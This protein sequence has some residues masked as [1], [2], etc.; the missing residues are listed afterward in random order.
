M[1]ATCK[2]IAESAWFQQ[3]ITAVILFA[4]I[5]VGAETYP[6]FHEQYAGLMHVLDRIVLGIFTLEIVVKMV[7]Q[8]SKPWRYFRDPW[9]VFDFVV[10]TASFLPL[11]AGQMI[12]VLRLVRL[13]RVLRLVR[14]LPK[15]QILVAALLKSIPSMGYVSLLLL[16]LFYVYG[17]AAVF[18][19]AHNDPIHFG[20]LQTSLLT[21]FRVVTLEDWTDVMYTQMWGCAKYGYE[22]NPELCTNSTAY[23][24]GSPIFFVSFVLLGTMI[25]LNLFIGVIMHG[26]SEAHA[27]A[28]RERK[29]A[30]RA[31][32]GEGAP[33]LDEELAELAEMVAN[34]QK[35]LAQAQRRARALRE[36]E[37]PSGREARASAAE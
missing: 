15:L 29:E 37:Q 9:N 28:E 31:A 5:L 32:R 11:G 23:P 6:T 18:L 13:L 19:F 34:L 25:I 2:R 36:A 35:A 17:V 21:L 12:V 14:A 20:D 8:G 30:E 26:M 7:A 1:V 27:E 16:L 24:L 22:S 33:K 4:G 10:V 3:F